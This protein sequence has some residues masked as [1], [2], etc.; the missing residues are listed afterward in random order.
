VVKGELPPNNGVYRDGKGTLYEGGTRVCGL[1]NWPG[2]LAPAKASGLVH[3]VDMYP[4]LTALAGAKTDKAKPLDGV[5]FWSHLA[6]GKPSPRTEI[7]Y[8]VEPFR[9]A[10]RQGDLKLMWLPILPDRVEL[11]DLAKDPSER[12]NIAEGHADAVERLK[13]RIEE[14]AKAAA[15][16][17]LL[18]QMIKTTFGAPP[19][20]AKGDPPPDAGKDFLPSL[21][22]GDD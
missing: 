2:R 19:S 6:E 5:D 21:E 18:G 17:L 1:A 13:K 10:V 15:P 14:L 7:V 9:A 3:V 22:S 8:N 16:P 11:Y 20:T 4:T 12:T